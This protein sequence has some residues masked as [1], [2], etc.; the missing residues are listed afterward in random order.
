MVMDFVTVLLKDRG[1]RFLMTL[2]PE[3]L[4]RWWIS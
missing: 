1:L 2:V 3:P 4:K